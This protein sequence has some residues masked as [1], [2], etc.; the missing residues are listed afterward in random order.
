M[1]FGGGKLVGD[2]ANFRALEGARF[3][4]TPKLDGKIISSLPANEIVPSG[5]KVVGDSWKD[6]K[7]TTSEWWRHAWL[8]DNDGAKAY[9][10]GYLHELTL[11]REAPPHDPRIDVVLT[12]LQSV[13]SALQAAID[14]VKNTLAKAKEL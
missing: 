14:V 7:G 4:A 11:V 6:A 9:V 8:Y 10:E 2:P 13:L 3:R 12:G 5:A 1:R